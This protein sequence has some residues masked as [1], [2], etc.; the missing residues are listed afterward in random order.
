M[1]HLI[2]DAKMFAVSCLVS[3]CASMDRLHASVVAV[4]A[5]RV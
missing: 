5:V 4:L 3:V 1:G 2:F